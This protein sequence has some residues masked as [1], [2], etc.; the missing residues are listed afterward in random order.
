M[1]SIRSF[2]KIDRYLSCNPSANT[3]RST[4]ARGGNWLHRGNA[5]ST[6]RSS[7]FLFLLITRVRVRRESRCHLICVRDAV[8][9]RGL[10]ALQNSSRSVDLC[11]FRATHDIHILYIKN[12]A[13]VSPT[14][15]R[16]KFLF[17]VLRLHIGS[18]GNLLSCNLKWN[19]AISEMGSCR[20]ISCSSYDSCCSS[21]ASK[22]CYHF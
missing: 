12:G 18:S 19:F 9:S 11:E 10:N 5:A 3:L 13:N 2:D 14:T 17:E 22:K 7:R 1:R 6:R 8:L 4:R 16:E 21:Y 20:H 15:V